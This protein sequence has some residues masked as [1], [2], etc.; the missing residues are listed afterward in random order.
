LLCAV[1]VLPLS[2]GE[3]KPKDKKG[4]DKK[5]KNSIGMK[6]VLIPKASS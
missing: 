5:L 2:G 6:L 4:P 1:L 3:D